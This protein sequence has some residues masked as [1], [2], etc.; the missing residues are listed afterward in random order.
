[1]YSRIEAAPRWRHFIPA[2]ESMTV[3]VQAIKTVKPP[4]NTVALPPAVE[5]LIVE[6]T[7]P[8]P[9]DAESVF[10]LPET[11][12]PIPQV[13]DS[14]IVSFDGSV[15]NNALEILYYAGDTPIYGPRTFTYDAES[16]SIT[17]QRFNDGEQQID[18]APAFGTLVQIQVQVTQ[19]KQNLYTR[20]PIK[21]SLLIQGARPRD[22][23]L[24]EPD[25]SVFNQFQG[26]YRC[27]LKL[28]TR[29]AHGHARISDDKLAFEYK[30]DLGYEGSDAFAYRLVNSM[31][32]ESAAYCIHVSVGKKKVQR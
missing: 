13:V 25:G 23:N 26:G 8:T 32:Q 10:A 2:G 12:I 18:R 15:Q 19:N 29:A 21:R 14:L 6:Y 20:I 24:I 9:I 31:G 1:M 27:T 16:N 4:P 17:Y 3:Q 7:A 28:A 22:P 5:T 30:P 11:S